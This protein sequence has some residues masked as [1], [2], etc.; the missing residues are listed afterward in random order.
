MPLLS[1]APLAKPPGPASEGWHPKSRVFRWV[2]GV[3]DLGPAVRR[4][5]DGLD[6]L[7]QVRK[8]MMKPAWRTLRRGAEAPGLLLIPRAPR[9][10]RQIQ[11]PLDSAGGTHRGLPLS[12]AEGNSA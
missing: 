9:L 6:D 4:L 2:I 8:P 12:V 11:S 1:N 7:C 10:D 3:K 5:T